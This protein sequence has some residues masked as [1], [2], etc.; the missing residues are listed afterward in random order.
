MLEG[1]VGD[2]MLAGRREIEV[3]IA[4]IAVTLRERQRFLL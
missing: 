3:G 2:A 4:A 1:V